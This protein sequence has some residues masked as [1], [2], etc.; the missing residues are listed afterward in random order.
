MN[1]SMPAAVLR[2]TAFKICRDY[3]KGAWNSITSDTMGWERITG[4][5]SNFLYKCSLPPS[6]PTFE[7]EPKEVLIRIYG[8]IHG[9]TAFENI[10]VETAIFTLLSERK[11]GPKLYGIFPGGRVEEF[12]PAP[13]LNTKELK[14]PSISRQIAQHL[15]RVHCLDVPISRKPVWMWDTMDRWVRK[16]EQDVSLSASHGV[17]ADIIQKI[18]DGAIRRELDWLKTEL[19]NVRSP[20]VFAHNDLQEGNILVQTEMNNNEK[21]NEPTR[22]AI[23]DFEYCAY[24]YRGFDLANHFCEWTYD[25]KAKD[26]KHPY[27]LEIPENWPNN[28]QQSL[29]FESYLSSI[30]KEGGA[31]YTGEKWTKDFLFREVDVFTLGPHFFWFLWAMVN[32]P[33]SEI[34]FGYGDYAACRLKAY[35]EK[36]HALGFQT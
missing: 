20:V 36:K 33:R 32:A 14:I 13:S 15:A 18:R 17:P 1:I 4:G 28:E 16:I 7:G 30:A 22:V 2:H 25:Y 24:N 8:Q 3:L 5:L 19:R 26:P 10:I 29:F 35:Y 31:L 34:E 23:I 12:I 27:F 9:E 21:R 6:V 11:L